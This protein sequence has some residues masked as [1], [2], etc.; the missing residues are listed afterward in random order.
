MCEA[1]FS[2]TDRG[3]CLLVKSGLITQTAAQKELHCESWNNVH[4]VMAVTLQFHLNLYL[5]FFDITYFPPISGT[6]R[7]CVKLKQSLNI[8]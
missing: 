7:Q 8:P 4:Q 3:C 5:L 2:T 1:L 6:C